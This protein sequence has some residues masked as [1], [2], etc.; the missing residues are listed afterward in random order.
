MEELPFRRPDAK[1]S[2]ESGV[3]GLHR[4]EGVTDY[5][6]EIKMRLITTLDPSITYGNFPCFDILTRGVSTS[7]G[8]GGYQAGETTRET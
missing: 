5:A 8:W 2:R 4:E 6:V 3:G 1:R 7:Q